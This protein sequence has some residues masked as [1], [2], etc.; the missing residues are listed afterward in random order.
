MA[1]V[2]EFKQTVANS[3][4]KMGN[5]YKK[6][7]KRFLAV[8]PLPFTNLDWWIVPI[9]DL[10]FP[11]HNRQIQLPMGVAD[12]TMLQTVPEE[13]L[14]AME[15]DGSVSEGSRAFVAKVYRDTIN[16]KASP[17]V[18]EHKD[19]LGGPITHVTEEQLDQLNKE[20]ESIKET[21]ERS[22]LYAK[23]RD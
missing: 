10:E 23:T 22:M 11:V 14:L 21:L 16:G 15:P 7:G 8:F 5:I 9:L 12:V 18:L 17:E 6:D 20:A 3:K 1:S 4:V 13:T 2:E 19:L